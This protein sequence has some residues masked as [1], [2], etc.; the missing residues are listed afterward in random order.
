MNLTSIHNF[1]H[2]LFLFAAFYG[3]GKVHNEVLYTTLSVGFRWSGDDYQY[4]SHC[5]YVSA[6]PVAGAYNITF[7]LHTVKK[8][9]TSISNALFS[10]LQRNVGRFKFGF[11]RT[12][13]STGT[14]K[15]DIT[16]F[17]NQEVYLGF[18][19]RNQ[20][21]WADGKAIKSEIDMQLLDLL[22]PKTEEDLAPVKKAEKPGINVLLT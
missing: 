14:L 2:F 22:G 17:E 19:Y 3:P 16:V 9:L 21:K 8:N 11:E 15:T 18:M 6:G 1:H 5:S 7:H 13:T 10:T 4:S 12:P 20:L